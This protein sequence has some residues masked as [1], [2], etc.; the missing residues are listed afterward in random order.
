MLRGI[1]R[2]GASL[3]SLLTIVF[4]TF[5]LGAPAH[6][7]D[8]WFGPSGTLL[9]G[10]VPPAGEQPNPENIVLSMSCAEKGK[11]IVLFVAETGPVLQ[12]NQPVRV[13]LSAGG[14]TSAA[15]GRTLPNELAGVP[16][17]RVNFPVSAKVFGAMSEKSS[18]ELRAD[19]WRK[20]LPLSGIGGRLTA[21]LALC[22]S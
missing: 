6:S 4:A 5:L 15:V 9:Y 17:I 22:G 18:L 3:T 7:A 13:E 10:D 20:T 11:A 19:A 1:V 12:P 14:V 16:S 21:L 8:G 2:R